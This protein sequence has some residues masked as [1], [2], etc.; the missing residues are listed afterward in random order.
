MKSKIEWSVW[1][2]IIKKDGKE[3]KLVKSTNFVESFKKASNDP[4]TLP[5][6]FSIKKIALNIFKDE[7]EYYK[8]L[9]DTAINVT[10]EKIK[11]E[12]S[13][14]D[15]YVIVLSLI[16]ISEPTRPY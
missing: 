1:F 15:K 9:R 13:K 16:H 8:A 3:I 14:D 5:M 2:G 12:L 7:S 4:S 10:S 6:P 11:K